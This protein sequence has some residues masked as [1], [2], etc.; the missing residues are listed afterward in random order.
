MENLVLI[1]YGLL[2]L[3]KSSNYMI[4][5]A[6]RRFKGLL[7]GAW[8]NLHLWLEVGICQF[9]S[10]FPH[11]F[12]EIFTYLLLQPVAVN[13]RSSSNFARMHIPYNK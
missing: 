2:E 12:A 10:I 8:M 9:R 7:L 11:E 1:L 3:Q 6:I 13:W 5:F 4:A